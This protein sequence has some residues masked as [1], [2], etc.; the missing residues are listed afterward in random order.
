LARGRPRYHFRSACS[1]RAQS[2]EPIQA[3]T[4]ATTPGQP[5][6]VGR[7]QPK[8]LRGYCEQSM[9]APKT[10]HGSSSETLSASHVSCLGRQGPICLCAPPVAFG[11][12][13]AVSPSRLR[14][15]QLPT[16]CAARP[17]AKMSCPIER[18]QCARR[19]L[20][21]PWLAPAARLI[22]RPTK[23]DPDGG[24]CSRPAG[25]GHSRGNA[26][27]S[28]KPAGRKHPSTHERKERIGDIPSPSRRGDA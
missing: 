18:P 11:A 12:S 23:K 9:E 5:R 19:V 1:R 22:R 16:F 7:S 8:A 24:F 21:D 4:D 20:A 6:S 14:N 2:A 17:A 25:I 26:Q 15:G 13:A 3:G 27:F 28:I 10:P